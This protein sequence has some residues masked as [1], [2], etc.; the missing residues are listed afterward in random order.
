MAISPPFSEMQAT[1][2]DK[3]VWF[4]LGCLKYVVYHSFKEFQSLCFLSGSS[5]WGQACVIGGGYWVLGLTFGV[6]A[7][8]ILTKV[9]DYL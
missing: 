1:G 5:H 2:F 9:V 4:D 7:A 8:Y 6:V 3:F